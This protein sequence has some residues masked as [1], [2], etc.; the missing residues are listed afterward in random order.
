MSRRLLIFKIAP[1]A[2]A[3]FFFLGSGVQAQEIQ[4]KME[5]GIPVVYNP[6]EPV[7]LPNMPSRLTL[8]EDLRLGEP[9]E[10]QNYPFSTLSWFVVDDEGNI[11]TVDN[12]EGCFKVFDKTGEFLHSFGRKGQGPGELQNV[13]FLTLIEGKNIGAVDPSNHRFY[14]FSRDGECLKQVDLG[15]YW[16][17]ERVKCDSRGFLYANFVTVNRVEEEVSFTVDLIKFDAEFRPITTLESFEVSRKRNEVNMV[18]KR[19][20]Y[21][22]RND[23][24]LVWG[25]NTDYVMNLVN[26]DGNVIRRIVKDYDPVKFTD[27]D[28]GTYYKYQFGDRVLPP[29]IKLNYPKHYYPYNYLF[30]DDQ[31][32]ILVRT[33]NQ[34]EQEDFFFDMFDSEGRYF[35][36]FALP[37]GEMPCVV[38]KNK[39]YS[40]KIDRNE[41]PLLRRYRMVWE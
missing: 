39:L 18:E 12:E 32:R 36:K 2:M 41:L 28:R 3:A 27:K 1:V 30:C 23:D 5:D 26:S 38:K 16:R 14:H 21:D 10:N 22:L 25:I 29:E 35:V 13:S 15:E 7:V 6:K 34:D 19:F 8:I 20:G 11:I 4:I 31:G 37:W 33:N 17:V 9:D 40:I 24:V